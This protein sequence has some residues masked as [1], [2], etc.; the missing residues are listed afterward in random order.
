MSYLLDTNIISELV[1]PTPNESVLK[2]IDA[3]ES[4]NLLRPQLI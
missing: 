2:W 1:K 3:I 4:D